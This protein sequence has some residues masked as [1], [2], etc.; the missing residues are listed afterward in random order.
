MPSS[1]WAYTD[2]GYFKELGG[3]TGSVQFLVS[4]T[5][6]SGSKYFVYSTASN[7]IGIGLTSYHGVGDMEVGKG[8]PAPE[9]KVHIVGDVSVTG[10]IY[11]DNYIIK[12]VSQVES[13]GDTKFGDTSADYHVFTGS[14]S[15]SQKLAIG[16]D[17]P[18]TLLHVRNGTAGTIATIDGAILT[19]ES[20][21]KPKIHF[22]SPGAYGGSIV[23]GSPTDNDEGQ[24]DYDHGSDRFL[25]KTGGNTKMT[26]LGSNVGIGTSSPSQLLDVDGTATVNGLQI[27]SS[28][29]M[30]NIL[31]EDDMASDSA[32][33]LATQQSIKA[34]VDTTVTAQDLD[35]QGDS[36]GALS[37]DLDS[38][39][40]SIVGGTGV[41]T[42]GSGNQVSIAT[43]AAQTHVTSVGT[44]TSLA[45]TGDL[46][47]DTSTLKVDSTNNSVGIGTAAPADQPDEKNDL[48]VGN[49]S[50]HHGMTIASGVTSIGTIRFAPNTSVNDIEGWIDYSGN[51]KKMRFGTDGLNTRMTIDNTGKVGIGT[52]T[53]NSTL[54][55]DG[56]IA[57]GASGYLNFGTTDGS[58]GYG[59]RDNSGTV[60]FKNS[61]GSWATFGAGAMTSYVLEDADGTEV[62]VGDG[63][64]VKLSGSNGIT[65]NFTDTDSGSDADPYDLTL[66]LDLAAATAAAVTVS[67]DSIAIIDADDSSTT[68]KESIADLITAVAGVT[69][70]TG[71]T[72]TSGVLGVTDLH[73]VG[74]DG[75]AN[76]LLTDD[77]DGTVTSE[78]KAK[79]DGATMTLGDG[80][81][82]DTVL[83]F[84]GNAVDF[85]VALDDSEDDFAI[86]VGNSVTPN[87]TVIA[88]NDSGQI[89]ARDAFAANVAGT[90]GTFAGGDTSPSV[91]TGNLWKTDNSGAHTIDDFDDG[92]AGQTIVVLS[93]HTVTFDV[94]STNLHGGSTNIV[95]ANGDMTVWANADG[96]NWYLVQFMDVSADMSSPAAAGGTMSSFSLAGDAGSA[97]TIED[98]NTLT[99]SGGTG[100]DTA[101]GATDTAVITLDLTEV[102]TNSAVANAVLTSDGDGTLTAETGL[103]FS[104]TT[105]E[106]GSDASSIVFGE[107]GEV[108]LSHQHNTGLEIIAA[109]PATDG[110]VGMLKLTA[111]STGTPAAGFGAG[112]VF[113]AETA[114]GSPGN[115]EIGGVFDAELTDTTSTSED[116]AFVWRLMQNGASISE[117][118]RLKSDGTIALSAGSAGD[119]NILFDI[120]GSGKWR[121]G[122]DDSD[123]DK[124]KIDG[125]GG[126]IG[127]STAFSINS[128]GQTGVGYGGAFTGYPAG[129]MLHV[130]NVGA[131]SGICIQ[132]NANA[133]GGAHL[134]FSKSRNTTPGTT[135][136]TVADNDEL[137]MIVWG[138]ADGSDVIPAAKIA[139]ITDG[140][141][142]NDQIPTRME[143][144][145]AAAG[146]KLTAFGGADTHAM[147]IINNGTLETNSGLAYKTTMHTGAG[148]SANIS[149]ASCFHLVNT[150]SNTHTLNLPAANSVSAGQ[151]FIIKDAGNAGSNNILVVRNGS[152]TIDGITS[153]TINSN[154]GS[155]SIVSNGSNTWHVI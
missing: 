119:P 152:D 79:V 97:Q 55:V 100:I 1:G 87:N 54:T 5:E 48:V 28:A 67:A 24:I 115:T 106:I 148:G 124:F 81:A 99:I 38:E 125:G 153:Y 74:V 104:S 75:S 71:L 52:S 58:S 140:T 109:N 13:D 123:S 101:A 127:S 118:M 111:E 107:H 150:A 69:A 149:A 30:A 65:I 154:Y 133:A 7:N 134:L 92:I 145:V 46:T 120:N 139:A 105:L 117:R 49:S 15:V 51:T 14:V 11:A 142:A 137:G 27:A 82:E 135:D 155:I 25:F 53:I 59:F 128:G 17:T 29:V 35:F 60:E 121:L 146:E 32:T 116:F 103:K 108:Q 147:R 10:S 144:Y 132:Q 110:C 43:D 112:L 50:G 3:P 76:Q 94:T 6:L 89:Q 141:I 98:G 129:S 12:N 20:S 131:N 34:Y 23:F 61:G 33:A 93:T 18:E 85:Y 45:V 95:T 84:D 83:M 56:N 77:G 21:E 16:I 39:T 143:F 37:I 114:A 36:G 62:T 78:A 80:T 57:A 113:A 44:L 96:T 40:L 31:D 66:T 151:I 136:T 91:A 68:K 86:G 9:H 70:T 2:L 41:T 126:L 122:V 102:M 73:P 138:G 90:F 88:I 19:L 64:E 4:Q 47:V 72:A 26:I 63:N 8:L 130:Q 22:Q 42:T